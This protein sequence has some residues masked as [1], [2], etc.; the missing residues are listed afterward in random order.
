MQSIRSR[1]PR[2]H[3]SERLNPSLICLTSPAHPPALPPVTY[4]RKCRSRYNHNKCV[5][6]SETL[7]LQA[8]RKAFSSLVHD[9]DRY[10]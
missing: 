7:H 8:N 9:N 1:S 2:A 6:A 3:F 5:N 4:T 10:R